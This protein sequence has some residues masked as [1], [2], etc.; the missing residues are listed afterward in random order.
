MNKDKIEIWFTCN[1]V[2]EE[3]NAYYDGLDMIW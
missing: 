2:A 3:W 1:R